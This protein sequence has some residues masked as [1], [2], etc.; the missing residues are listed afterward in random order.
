MAYW[1]RNRKIWR[2]RSY[3]NPDEALEAVGLR[4]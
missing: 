3:P 4:E 2:L 1:F